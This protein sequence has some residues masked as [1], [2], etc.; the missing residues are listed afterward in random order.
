MSQS[1]YTQ[2]LSINIA[3]INFYFFKEEKTLHKL[4]DILKSNSK[5]EVFV[6]T[7][8]LSWPQLGGLMSIRLVVVASDKQR[9][10]V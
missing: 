4:F 2:N 3:R 8:K 6:A 10:F 1:R 7:D 9:S 5:E